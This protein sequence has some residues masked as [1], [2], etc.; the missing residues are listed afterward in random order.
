MLHDLLRFFRRIATYTW[1]SLII[2]V[3]FT[4]NTDQMEYVFLLLFLGNK[5]AY[6]FNKANILHYH[7]I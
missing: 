3:Q 7:Y 5:N 2:L 6:I 1:Q 4:S